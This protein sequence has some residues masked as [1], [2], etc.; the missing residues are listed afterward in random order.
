MPMFECEKRD[1]YGTLREAIS[2]FASGRLSAKLKERGKTQ[3]CRAPQNTRKRAVFDLPSA[4]LN[5]IAVPTVLLV[6]LLIWA[7]VISG[8][9]QLIKERRNIPTNEGGLKQKKPNQ[10][11]K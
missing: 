2:P 1:F 11:V 7:A 10:Y 6:P 5:M 3:S 8:L 4:M 9:Y